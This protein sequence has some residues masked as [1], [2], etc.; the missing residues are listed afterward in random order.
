[1]DAR[2]FRDEDI[3]EINDWFEERN[4]AGISLDVLSR[5]GLIV[6]GVA[7]GFLYA[8]DS[9]ICFLDFYVSNPNIPY[10]Y[11]QK[12]MDIITEKHLAT[13]TERKYR[14]IFAGSDKSGIID[15]CK[16][17]GFTSQGSQEFFTMELKQ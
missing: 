10:E 12:A 7:C 5:T 9:R 2:V 14:F 1:M 13:A 8:T 3:D 15:R 6:P 17:L 4:E 16:R 11:R